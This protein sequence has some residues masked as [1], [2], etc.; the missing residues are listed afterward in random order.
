LS[1]ND[2]SVQL[3]K[4]EIKKI[5]NEIAPLIGID[6]NDFKAMKKV[7]KEKFIKIL[8]GQATK[9]EKGNVSGGVAGDDE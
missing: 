8:N 6:L 3:C 5:V 7:V 9:V 1:G 4:H 2:K